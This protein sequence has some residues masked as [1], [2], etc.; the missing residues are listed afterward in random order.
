MNDMELLEELA[1]AF[2]ATAGKPLSEAVAWLVDDHT[3]QTVILKHLG[4]GSEATSASVAVRH[5]APEGVSRVV[6]ALDAQVALLRRELLDAPP[7]AVEPLGRTIS[8]Y[9][10]LSADVRDGCILKP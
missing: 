4:I 3:R 2:P 1:R 10:Q 6:R 7:D 9:L 5:V 8:E